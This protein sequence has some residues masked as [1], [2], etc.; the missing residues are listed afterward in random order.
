MKRPIVTKNQISR[1]FNCSMIDKKFKF[2]NPIKLV[3]SPSLA[4]CFSYPIKLVFGQFDQCMSP[5]L[6]T[7]L[8]HK[9]E[10]SSWCIW[11]IYIHIF[12]FFKTTFATSEL[13][14]ADRYFSFF[15]IFILVYLY[16]FFRPLDICIEFKNKL[17]IANSHSKTRCGCQ[18]RMWTP[19]LNSIYG[20]SSLLLRKNK[21]TITNSYSK[22]ITFNSNSSD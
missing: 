14:W 5:S 6:A 22:P 4:I 13:F 11:I 17:I 20:L 7:C 19:P 15:S 8:V 3:W 12:R 1:N 2:S 16:T 10:T 9:P 21:L 18:C